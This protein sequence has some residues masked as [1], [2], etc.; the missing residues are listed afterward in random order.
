MLDYGEFS[1]VLR[2]LKM[3]LSEWDIK[4]IM[5][6]V[7]KNCDGDIQ[8]EEFMQGAVDLLLG[9]LVKRKGTPASDNDPKTEINMGLRELY[10]EEI[11]TIDKV[12]QK[13]FH[14]CDQDGT[15]YISKQE[16]KHIISSYPT[17]TTKERNLILIQ[18]LKD[19]K[20]YYADL[21]EHLIE[22]RCA[23]ITS[24]LADIH[25]KNIES[26]IFSACEREDPNKTGYLTVTQLQRALLDNEFLTL[27]I[28]EIAVII[29]AAN[30]QGDNKVN[31]REFAQTAKKIITEYYSSD[32]KNTKAAAFSAGLYEHKGIE[33]SLRYDEF[34]LFGVIHDLL[35]EARSCSNSTTRRAEASSRAGSISTVSGRP[36]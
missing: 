28:T 24:K 31:Y 19:D 2:A 22:V 26:F 7:D 27:S 20:Y 29:G 11:N 25:T 14:K 16:F 8:R 35:S 17:V 10:K 34:E 18:Y 4:V 12:L 23:S 9:Y 21:K 15:G 32:A 30:P 6:M 13:A 36:D 1:S 3:N 33:D 5:A